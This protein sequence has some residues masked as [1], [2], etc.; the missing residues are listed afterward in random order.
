MFTREE[1][2]I[3]QLKRGEEKAYQFLFEN[4]YLPLC[5]LANFY[6]GDPYVA[7][8]LVEDLF[9]YLWKERET[10]QIH[11]SLK[12][13]LFTSVRNR[14]LNHLKQSH[15]THE[16]NFSKEVIDYKEFPSNELSILMKLTEQELVEKIKNCV[17]GLPDE[18]RTVFRLSRYE[19][20]SYKEISE[21]QDISVNTVRY[22]IKNALATLRLE[23]KDYL[24]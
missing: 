14:S 3:L 1:D 18:C 7:E 10:L 23:L 9:Y 15:N 6:V 16:T 21:K 2:L 19:N 5:R 24:S 12:N 13:Y 22:H 8:N 4:Y 17:E 20:L 11:S